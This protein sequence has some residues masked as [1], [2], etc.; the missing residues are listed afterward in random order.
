MLPYSQVD[1]NQTTLEQSCLYIHIVFELLDKIGVQIISVQTIVWNAI[2]WI[3]DTGIWMA[4]NEQYNADK[5]EG[6]A[7]LAV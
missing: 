7:A 5:T 3:V 4:V 1:L 2:V 6:I